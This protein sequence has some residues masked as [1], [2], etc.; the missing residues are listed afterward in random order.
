M[1]LLDRGGGT[2]CLSRTHEPGAQGGESQELE[3]RAQKVP[4]DAFSRMPQPVGMREAHL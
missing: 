2:R 3:E 4:L 1:S